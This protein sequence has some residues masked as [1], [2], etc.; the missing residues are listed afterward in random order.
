MAKL[1][2]DE[3]P[4]NAS[5]RQF[6]RTLTM[7]AMLSA[8]SGLDTPSFARTQSSRGSRT[9]LKGGTVITVDKTLG[10]FDQADVL[11]EGSRIAAVGRNLPAGDA[12]VIPAENMIVMPGF[13]DT[14]RHMWQG[15]LRNTSPSGTE[16]LEYRNKCGPVYRPE[17]AYIGDTVSI[18]SALDAGV[19]TIVDWSHIQN[20]PEHT[21]AVIRALQNGGIRAVFAYGWPMPGS[22]PWWKNSATRFPGD[23]RRLRK[24]YFS[25]DD[26][27]LTLALGP[28]SINNASR[29]W[30]RIQSRS[31]RN[32]RWRARWARVFHFIPVA[33]EIL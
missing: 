8:V 13:I 20:T 18:L 17:D 2:A 12:E 4:A 16:Y 28:T 30:T 6:C 19:T 22:V 33:G 23:I 27:L 3:S 1:I 31:N 11:I 9:L 24:Q 32:G 10:D 15:Q 5:R 26:Q 14:H 21:D 7:G 25:S 29:R